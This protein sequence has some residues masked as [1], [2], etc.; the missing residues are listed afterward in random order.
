MNK[1][2]VFLRESS[3]ARILIPIGIIL[4]IFGVIMFFVNNSNKDYVKTE[5]TISNVVLAQEAYTDA[6]GN[7]VEATYTVSV[8]YTVDGKEYDQVLG[9][10]PEDKI[11]EK[12]TIY[13]NPNDPSRITQSKSMVIPVVITLGGIVAFV[14]GIISGINSYKR[15]KKMKN[16]EE[17]WKNARE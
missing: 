17:E 13:Y 11:G 14:G 15:Y 5:G 3:T 6:D 16:Q 10:L 2:S 9:E 12:I 8:K 7:E 1:M 4:I